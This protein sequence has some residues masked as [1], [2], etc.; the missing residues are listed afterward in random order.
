MVPV[1]WPNND[2][3]L[4]LVMP[5]LPGGAWLLSH[6]NGDQCEGPQQCCACQHDHFCLAADSHTHTAVTFVY[7]MP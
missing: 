5:L 1:V 7:D 2:V 3:V 4:A 6:N